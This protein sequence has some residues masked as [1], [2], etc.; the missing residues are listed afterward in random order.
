MATITMHTMHTMPHTFAGA[1]RSAGHGIAISAHH[2][3][4]YLGNAVSFSFEQGSRA[5]DEAYLA[6][7]ADLYDLE[8]RMRD[9]DH[10]SRAPAFWS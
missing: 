3:L 10:G 7:S 8:R 6:G 9:L 1:I 2:F 5:R 4:E